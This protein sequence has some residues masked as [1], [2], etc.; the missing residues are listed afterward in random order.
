[1]KLR[2][3]AVVALAAVSTL[4][5]AQSKPEDMI[6]LRQGGLQ[7]LSRNV[8]ILNSMAKGDVPYNKEVAM[9]KAEFVNTLAPEI[10][11]AGFGT[12]SDKGLPTRAKPAVWAEGDNFK[13]AQEKLF[14]VLKKIQAGA[15]DQASL[16]AAMADVGGACK[17]CHD[18]FRDTS[19]H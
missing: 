13:A 18:N 4:A 11:G 15:G 10:F 9:Q 3:L 17:N 14:A 6:R 7:L 12:G 1:M 5:Q 8:S 2:Y 19:Y 16:K